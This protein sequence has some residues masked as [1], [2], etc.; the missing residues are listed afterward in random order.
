MG[1]GFVGASW[2]S[3]LASVEDTGRRAEGSRGRLESEDLE[4]SAAEDWLGDWERHGERERDRQ[5]GRVCAHWARQV[6]AGAAEAGGRANA[7][8]V[9]GWRAFR[10]WTSRYIDLKRP[11]PHLR[12][13]LLHSL[14]FSPHLGIDDFRSFSSPLL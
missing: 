8:P 6:Q 11:H 14:M 1:V 4:R 2:V 13:S 9:W 3:W 5:R 7:R 10:L 12:S